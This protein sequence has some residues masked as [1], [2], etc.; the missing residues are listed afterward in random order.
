M[1]S[2]IPTAAK[3]TVNDEPP[4]DTN[5]S[6]MP[7]TGTTVTTTPTLIRAW[8]HIHAVI[9]AAINPPKVSGARSAVRKPA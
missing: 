1:E 2:R 8:K 4:A 7:V 6:V 9:P 3:L 5:G